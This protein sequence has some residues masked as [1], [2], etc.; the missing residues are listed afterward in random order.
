M[1]DRTLIVGDDADD[2]LQPGRPGP[3]RALR[4]ARWVSVIRRSGAARPGYGGEGQVVPV[5][6]R[7]HRRGL[8]LAGQ[9]H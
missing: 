7:W 6:R 9:G 5:R 2:G 4:A 8:R 3:P 1:A